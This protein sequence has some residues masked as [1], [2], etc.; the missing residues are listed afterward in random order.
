MPSLQ[1]PTT[2]RPGREN[3]CAASLRDRGGS[4]RR[5]QAWHRWSL[6]P[7]CG[8]K[9]NSFH[10]DGVG[11][12]TFDAQRATNAAIFVF[13][14]RRVLFQSEIVAQLRGKQSVEVRRWAQRR[15]R[16]DLQAQRGTDIGATAAENTA[17][18]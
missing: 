1:P 16:H 7:L 11:R 4:G 17:A 9:G 15:E 12:T 3:P 18:G 8:L 5:L 13:E 10:G 6:A 2:T 14:N